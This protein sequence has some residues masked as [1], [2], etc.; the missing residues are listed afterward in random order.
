MWTSFFWKDTAERALK[1]LAQALI[2]TLA[3]GT[4]IWD[5]DW[6]AS[7]GI[8]L[9]ATVVSVL[10]SIASVGVS[11]SGTASL[12]ASGA[13]RHAVDVENDK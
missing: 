11:D 8:A 5:L 9:T 13:G 6:A 12:V 1:T 2:A 10:T 3:V 4:P 7:V